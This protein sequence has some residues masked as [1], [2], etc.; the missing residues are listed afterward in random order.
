[1]CKNDRRRPKQNVEAART[2]GASE[3]P[4][5]RAAAVGRAG[6]SSLSTLATMDLHPHR[7]RDCETSRRGAV[8]RG[9]RGTAAALSSV[10]AMGLGALTD[11][12]PRSLLFHSRLCFTARGGGTTTTNTA[13]LPYMHMCRPHRPLLRVLRVDPP[14]FT[15][16]IPIKKNSSFSTQKVFFGWP[17][18]MTPEPPPSLNTLNRP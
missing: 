1:M 12:V 3:R 10:A 14:I 7:R 15:N 13:L 6:R 11:Y 2:I 18:R 17:S 5:C 16:R 9:Q 4:K 8:G